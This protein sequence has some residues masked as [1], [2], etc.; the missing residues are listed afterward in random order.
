MA[1][2]FIMVYS[3]TR[4]CIQREWTKCS[5]EERTTGQHSFRQLSAMD[6]RLEKVFLLC[7]FF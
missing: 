5:V 7:Q 1:A 4:L 2:A 3:V 6:V